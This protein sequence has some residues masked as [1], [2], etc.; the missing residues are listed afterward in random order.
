MTVEVRKVD[1]V[2]R[3]VEEGTDNPFMNANGNPADGGAE[4]SGSD[5]E[6]FDTRL[7]QAGHIN[8]AVQKKSRTLNA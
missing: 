6:S 8:L 3:L 4:K 1:G 2:Y 7:R 5:Q